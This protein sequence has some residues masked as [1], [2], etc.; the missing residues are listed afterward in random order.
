MDWQS[1]SCQ[2]VSQPVNMS[3]FALLSVFAFVCLPVCLFF[4][5]CPSVYLPFLSMHP[6]PCL[7]MSVCFCQSICACPSLTQSF[8]ACPQ[9]C[10]TVSV[11]QTFSLS[12]SASV[13]LYVWLSFSEPVFM[14]N[15]NVLVCLYLG[16]PPS[17]SVSVLDLPVTACLS[18]LTSLVNKT[19]HT[20]EY[21]T[22]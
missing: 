21:F 3:V 17:V 8:P 16:P 11:C 1:C 20:L 10:L 13:C 5:L 14:Y 2:P 12:D 19:F 9:S 18:A 15:W 6:S 4:C 7:C 22:V